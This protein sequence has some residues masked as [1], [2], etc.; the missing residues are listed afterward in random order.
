[1]TETTFEVALHFRRQGQR[2]LLY[3]GRC[4]SPLAALA[5]VGDLYVVVSVLGVPTGLRGL[6]CPRPLDETQA[7]AK[8]ELLERLFEVLN[9]KEE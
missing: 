3:A 9:D 2:W 6:N 5:P 7:A 1:M 4:A 8:R